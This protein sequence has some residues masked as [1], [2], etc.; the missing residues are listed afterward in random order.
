MRTR[1]TVAMVIILALC[2][3]MLTSCI[4]KKAN[5][6]ITAYKYDS[7]SKYTAGDASVD[8][9]KVKELSIDWVSGSVKVVYGRSRSIEITETSKRGKLTDDELLRWMVDGNVL[10]IRFAKSNVTLN[11]L[12]KDLVVAVPEGMQLDQVSVDA[13]SADSDI[14]VRSK[15]YDIDEVSGDV[16]IQTD[17]VEDFDMDSVSG[18]ATLDLGVCPSRIDFDTVSG[19]CTIRIP[20]NSGFKVRTSTVS[21]KTSCSI[22]ATVSDNRIEAGDGKASFSFNSVSGDLRIESKQ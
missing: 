2:A 7:A 17:Y 8:P 5:G 11:D 4:I 13:V 16:T 22:P 15:S 21:G 12:Q 9:S 10:R 18:N 1:R 3:I 20:S 19:N 6:T 14:S